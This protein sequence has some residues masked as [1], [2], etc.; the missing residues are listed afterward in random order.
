MQNM[1]MYYSI[2]N[3]ADKTGLSYSFWRKAVLNGEV[4]F[5]ACGK[6]R[7]IELNDALIY[8]SKS[9]HSMDENSKVVEFNTGKAI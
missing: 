9:R 4:P 8:L 5:I 2:Q 7:M 3:I 1:P 6:K